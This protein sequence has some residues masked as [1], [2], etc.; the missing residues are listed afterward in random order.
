VND[1]PEQ[2]LES[3]HTNNRINLL[4]IDHITD[5][6]M[7]CSLSRRG[8][9]TITRQ[10]AHLHNNRAWHM[11]KRARHLA[12]GLH[13]FETSDE[14]DRTVL[15]ENLEHSRD[16]LTDYFQL[17]LTGDSRVRCFKKGPVAYLSYFIAHESHHRGNIL[18]TLKQCGHPV[19]KGVRYAIW[20]WDRR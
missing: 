8:G 18:L 6:G 7:A 15:R 13:V 10:F 3:W 14:P 4:L 12:G 16:V 17:V 9:R 5:D 19:E 2:I 11:Q 1:F 20:D